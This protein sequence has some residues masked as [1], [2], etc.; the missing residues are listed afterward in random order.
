[1]NNIRFWLIHENVFFFLFFYISYDTK[2]LQRL[3]IK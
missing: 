1:M 2:T 3:L